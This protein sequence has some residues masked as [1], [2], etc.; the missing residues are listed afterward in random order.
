VKPHCGF[1]RKGSDY[2]GCEDCPKY[3]WKEVEDHNLFE[4]N[5]V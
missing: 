4:M 1:N 5:L 3:K 2:Q